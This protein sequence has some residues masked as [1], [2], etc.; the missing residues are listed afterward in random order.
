MRIK[1]FGLTYIYLEEPAKADQSMLNILL[2]DP[3]FE[4]NE[5]MILA[6]FVALEVY[7]TEK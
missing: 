3:Y 2:T 7:V 5:A 6:E 4:I 1:S